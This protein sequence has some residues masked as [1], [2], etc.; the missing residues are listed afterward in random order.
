M[1]KSDSLSG[2]LVN[3]EQELGILYVFPTCALLNNQEDNIH[4]HHSS[5]SCEERELSE[6]EFKNSRHACIVSTSTMELGID[7]G[8]LD[9]VLQVDAPITVSSF[10]QRLWRTGRREGTVVN[11]TFFVQKE[12]KLL[13]AIAIVELSREGWVENVPLS[14]WTWHLLLHQIMALCL[15]RGAV[16]RQLVWNLLHTSYCFSAIHREEFNR[17]IEFL[18]E[19]EF[20]HDDSREA[21]SMGLEAE[22]VFGRRNFMEIYSVFSS[23]LEFEVMRL[24]GE[25]IGAVQWDF[26]EK[27]LE[28]RRAFIFPEKLGLSKESSGRKNGYMYSKPLRERYRNGKITCIVCDAKNASESPLQMADQYKD[29]R[30]LLPDQEEKQELLEQLFTEKELFKPRHTAVVEMEDHKKTSTSGSVKVRMKL[31]YSCIDGACYMKTRWPDFISK[32]ENSR[33]ISIGEESH[34][35][36]LI[37]VQCESTTIR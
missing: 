37:T 16:N 13:Q 5:L 18:L 27:L 2:C 32:A 26:L 12:Q 11:T 8:D 7:I 9:K 15:E 31:L 4:A 23:P 25:V 20:L 22:K 1:R 19:K 21:F 28:K 17:F 36:G 24:S 6:A 10:M 30:V 14:Q 3:Q 33:Y 34:N 35:P 29:Y